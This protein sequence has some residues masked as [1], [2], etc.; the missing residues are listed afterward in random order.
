[1]PQVAIA[2]REEGEAEQEGEEED[3]ESERLQRRR[4]RRGGRRRGRRDESVGAGVE[5][6]H[7]AANS[8]EIV[9]IDSDESGVRSFGYDERD[10]PPS[11]EEGVSAEAAVS[12][13]AL[14]LAATEIE[15]A[16]LPA[17]AGEGAPEAHPAPAVEPPEP[18]SSVAERPELSAEPTAPHETPSYTVPGAEMAG[19]DGIAT[20]ETPATAEVAEPGQLEEQNSAAVHT[21][22]E[23]ELAQ[24]TPSA[25]RD[26]TPVSAE[27]A[28][29]GQPNEQNSPLVHARP[30]PELAQETPS[31]SDA[32]EPASAQQQE[33]ALLV[34]E[35]TKKPENPRRGWWQR[36]IQS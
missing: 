13:P 20:P 8:I 14:A 7:A 16:S 32:A 12:E 27:A 11:A 28:E 22:S 1:M 21:E 23:P 4:G 31:V 36:L 6:G 34:Q 5:I 30:D 15:T 3:G 9:P 25:T 35:V 19:D 2:A 10:T 26:V 18:P 24:D 33:P 29:P 17:L